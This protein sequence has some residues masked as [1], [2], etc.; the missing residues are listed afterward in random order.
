MSEKEGMGSE[1]LTPWESSTRPKIQTSGPVGYLNK[2]LDL[3]PKIGWPAKYL[4]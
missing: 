3:L 2:E 4:Q 1:L